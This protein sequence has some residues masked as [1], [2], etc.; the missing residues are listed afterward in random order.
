MAEEKTKTEKPETKPENEREYII[1]LRRKWKN[2]PRYKRANKAIRTIR[3]FL[4]RHM[5]IR[6]RDLEKIKIDKYLNEAVWFRGIRKPPVKIRVKAVK[7]GDIIRVEAAELSE[8]LK[9]KKSRLEK[10]EQKAMEVISKKKAAMKPEEKLEEKVEKTEEE[11][12]EE[13]EKAKAG[14][15]VTKELGREAAKKV[16][17]GDKTIKRQPKRQ[18]RKALAK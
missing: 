15:E 12:K 4:V 8:K 18:Q 1:P 7:E 11:K 13:K 3:E 9:F 14:E 16:K 2:V 5:K 6:D 17:H 10:R